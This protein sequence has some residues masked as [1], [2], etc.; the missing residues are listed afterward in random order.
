VR[1]LVATDF[2]KQALV[3]TRRL[4]TPVYAAKVSG[5]TRQAIHK[6][7]GRRHGDRLMWVFIEP[8][9]PADQHSAVYVDYGWQD[10]PEDPTEWRR[11]DDDAQSSINQLVMEACCRLYGWQRL[12]AGGAP[13]EGPIS[14][15]RSAE[16]ELVPA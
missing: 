15:R 16:R 4:Y 6:S 8:D 3:R 11:W 9:L 13:L 7:A 10:E 5:T 14:P 1:Q 2:V 12:G